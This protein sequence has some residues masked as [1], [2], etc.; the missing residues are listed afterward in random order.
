MKEKTRKVSVLWVEADRNSIEES[1]QSG[2]AEGGEKEI[3]DWP[4]LIIFGIRERETSILS[5]FC[6][7]RLYQ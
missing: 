7:D 4:T 1:M 6:P 2:K 5:S 3:Q